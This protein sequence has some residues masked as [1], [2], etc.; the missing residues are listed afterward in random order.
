M[1][2]QRIDLKQLLHLI[3]DNKEFDVN[4]ILDEGCVIYAEDPKP[5]VKVLNY[6]INYLTPLTGQ[7]LEISLDL[8]GNDILMSMMAY[9]EQS[10]LPE[11]SDQVEDALKEYNADLNQ[12]HEAGKYIQFKLSFSK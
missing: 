1:A 12:I 10:D 2:E 5:L 3:P 6:L 7:P 4:F 9:C 11:I 8:R